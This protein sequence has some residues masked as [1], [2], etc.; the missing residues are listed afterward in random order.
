MYK[1]E[2]RRHKMNQDIRETSV[3]AAKR[4]TLKSTKISSLGRKLFSPKKLAMVLIPLGLAS[5][6]VSPWSRAK[7]KWEGWHLLLA[8][9]ILAL[10]HTTRGRNLIDI[11]TLVAFLEDFEEK[12]APTCVSFGE[13]PGMPP[14]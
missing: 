5:N 13:K 12:L 9:G 3:R 6:Q 2:R 10:L 14:I 8:K 11:W 7:D 1:K 4:L